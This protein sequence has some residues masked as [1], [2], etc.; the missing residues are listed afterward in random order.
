MV[1][2]QVVRTGLRGRSVRSGVITVGAQLVLV[3]ITVS[4][5]MVLARLL[6]P[7]DFG[8]LAMAL[9]LTAFAGTFR[10][11]GLP[12]A[13][14]Q[15]EELD[16][17]EA[18]AGFWMIVRSSGA[19]TVFVAAMAPM[20][21]WFYGEPSLLA[22][23]P[24]LGVTML[25]AG[26]GDQHEA[27]LNRSMRFGAL[28]AIEVSSSV[29]GAIT[30]IAAAVLGAG[31]WALVLQLVAFRV[32]RST[33]LWAVC[34]WR[35]T[36][37][38][39]RLRSSDSGVRALLAFGLPHSVSRVVSHVGSNLDQALV[40]YFG[41][42]STLGLYSGA[43]RWSQLPFRQIQS[44]LL[45]VAVASFSR[46]QHDPAAYRAGVRLGL[47]PVFAVSMPALAFLFVEARSVVLVLLGDQWLGAVTLFRILCVA[48]FTISVTRVTK[49]L[50]LS[51]GT[52]KREL[53]WGLLATPV[54]I[55]AVV[56]GVQWDAVGVAA[57]Y[58]VAVL[59]LAYPSVRY[60]LGASPISEGDFFGVAFRPALASII[61]GGALAVSGALLPGFGSL[62]VTLPLKAAIFASCFAL[63]WVL[64]PGG[65]RAARELLGLAS[66]LWVAGSRKRTPSEGTAR[67]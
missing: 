13:T 41:G 23:T 16:H 67:A 7:G 52:T 14:V 31:Y 65:R 33:A 25:C 64:L 63:C 38:E 27:L 40:G 21:A 19:V 29:A 2:T 43:L 59:V 28:T 10:D 45:G 66:E 36:A 26:L 57:G 51:E 53:S 32:T 61:A 62:F 8:L 9:S 49:W 4:S 34:D 39:G 18:N 42:A 35:P 17:R 58:T 54:M 60:C 20:L 46:L 6:T 44:P 50:Y 56:I 15:R 3:A 24:V 47:L 55:V 37:Y 22:I 5:T 12:M 11:L 48:G 1:G 30:G